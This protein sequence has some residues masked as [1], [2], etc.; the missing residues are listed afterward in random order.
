MMTTCTCGPYNPLKSHTMLKILVTI[1]SNP[2][3][4][5]DCGYCGNPWHFGCH[6]W[7]CEGLPCGPLCSDATIYPS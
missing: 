4:A 3:R 2:S 7:Y 5:S 1:A 6:T